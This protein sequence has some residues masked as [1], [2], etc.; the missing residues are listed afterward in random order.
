MENILDVTVRTPNRVRV[1]SCAARSTGA[2]APWNPL[3]AHVG[4][5]VTGGVRLRGVDPAPS[6]VV[7][8]G[9]VRSGS[10]PI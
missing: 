5:Q 3:M 7:D 6:L 4:N 1:A 9:S 8:A 2:I 10:P